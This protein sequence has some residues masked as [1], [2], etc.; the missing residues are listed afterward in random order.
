M[1]IAGLRGGEFGLSASELV[2]RIRSLL[3]HAE[4]AFA[5]TPRHARASCYLVRTRHNRQA[6]A[7]CA[8]F[9]FLCAGLHL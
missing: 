8:L 2:A 9:V 3:R 7:R 6:L 1:L 4:I 5:R